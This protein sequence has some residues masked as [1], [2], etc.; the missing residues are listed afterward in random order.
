MKL[1]MLLCCAVSGLACT[2]P[3]PAAT[4]PN[5]ACVDP[6]F[7]F[8]DVT[9]AIGG[10]PNQCLSVSCTPGEFEVCV[11]A[12][13]LS[14]N[15]T[16]DNFDRIECG[17]GCDEQSAGCL[18][19]C[20]PAAVLGC[21]DDLL[22]VCNEAGTATMVA[23]T[24]SLGCASDEA[25]CLSFQ[26]SNGLGPALTE[27]AGEPDLVLPSGSLIQTDQLIV[28]DAQGNP[29]PVKT[30]SLTQVNGLPIMVI[31]AAS[32]SMSDLTVTGTSPLAIVANGLITISGRVTA[33]GTGIV[34][35]PGARTI[36]ACVAANAQ[37]FDGICPQAQ[38]VGA[39]GGGGHTAGGRGGA[40]NVASAGA[41]STVF[42]PLVG[43]CPGG[44]QVSVAGSSFVRR[45]G[46]GGGALQ[47]VS[48]TKIELTG[49]GLIDVGGGGGQSTTGG[50]S[51]G[52]VVIEAPA[53][54]IVGN[55]A[56][57]VANGGAGGGCGLVGADGTTTTAA[58]PGQTCA[59]YFSGRGGTALDAPGNGCVIGVDTCDSSICPVIYGGG[60]GSVGVLKISTRD[61]TFSSSSPVLSIA[62]TTTTLMAQ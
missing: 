15:Q 52:A 7:P 29:I 24:C 34:R 53:V 19:F 12:T 62:V 16:G 55:S 38:S 14:C 60:G 18:P 11:G 44:S 25:R 3:N 61:G 36:G 41:A 59:N 4:C 8:C 47:I 56:G 58:A 26:P 20:T 21:T 49:A 45:G 42:S 22:T 6:A 10:M 54:A 5:G 30:G 1:M 23:E 57:V 40:N 2:K 13:A 35:G 31:Q 46:G 32:I 43:G 28:Q 39:G 51:G 27:S 48:A 17:G 37:Q 33:R 50:G 9:G